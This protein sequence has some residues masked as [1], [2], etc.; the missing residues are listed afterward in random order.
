MTRV[1]Q[2]Y[3]SFY[4]CLM[5]RVAKVSVILP[6]Y[7]AEKTL[8]RALDSVICQTYE[9]FELILVNN[10]SDDLSVDIA[11]EYMK[12]DKRIQLFHEKV[13][14]VSYAVNLAVEKSAG[15][16]IART[17]ADDEMHPKRLEKQIAC[18]VNNPE[19]DICSCRAE[20]R[21]GESYAGMRY[22][23]ELTN[24][25][26]HPDAISVNRFRSLPVINPTLMFRASVFERFGM[27]L[28]NSFPEDYE[29]ILRVLS[30]GL[31]IY[32][33]PEVLHYWYDSDSRLTRTHERYTR[34][35]FWE[36]KAFYLNRYLQ[37]NKLTDKPFY[38]WG[39]G[40]KARKFATY[41]QKYG[42]KIQSFIDIDH[43]KAAGS[44]VIYFKDIP[45]P[46]TC[47]ICSLTEARTAGQKIRSFL[48]SRGYVE[49]QDFVLAG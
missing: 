8:M 38:V 9:E 18:L 24:R 41:L 5:K 45:L 28:H 13:Q 17:D 47:F 16:Y 1:C 22:F 49:M 15:M 10:N 25:W 33:L 46:R 31:K 4:F 23:T 3:Q 19:V 32:K 20:H 39:A 30:G 48:L 11:R 21:G 36:V 35:A 26:L 12:A 2:K 40:K 43:R 37:E 14:G 6:F 34:K 29:F 42:I 7:N 27:Y 44:D